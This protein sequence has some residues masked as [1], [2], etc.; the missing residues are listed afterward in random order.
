MLEVMSS[1]DKSRLTRGTGLK[2]VRVRVDNVQYRDI[3]TL[4]EL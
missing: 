3:S 1:S 2:V 4:I